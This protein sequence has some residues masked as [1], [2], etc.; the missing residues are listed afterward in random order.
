MYTTY[1]VNPKIFVFHIETVSSP[2]LLAKN[3]DLGV[4]F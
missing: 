3:N 2:G 4:G 1:Q